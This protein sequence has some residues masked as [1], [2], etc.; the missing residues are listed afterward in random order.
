MYTALQN[1]PNVNIAL[2]NG[3]SDFLSK[4]NYADKIVLISKIGIT[5]TDSYKTVKNALYNK[6]KEVVYDILI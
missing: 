3:T 1:L 4:V 5:N 2:C 6:Q